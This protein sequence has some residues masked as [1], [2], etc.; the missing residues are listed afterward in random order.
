MAVGAES[1]ALGVRP[2]KALG[3]AVT[4]VAELDPS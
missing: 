3:A 2:P 4:S 1:P